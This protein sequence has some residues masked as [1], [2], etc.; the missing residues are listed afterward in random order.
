MSLDHSWYSCLA[1]LIFI[2]MMACKI[3]DYP[4]ISAYPD[5]TT[6]SRF[7]SECHADV[8][9][10]TEKG[11]HGQECLCRLIIVGPPAWRISYRSR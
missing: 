11:Q 6:P 3:P 9:W 1:H 5:T 4:D 8:G 10:N 7:V 2:S